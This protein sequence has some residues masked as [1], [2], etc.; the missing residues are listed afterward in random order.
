MDCHSAASRP[1]QNGCAIQI[2]AEHG[3]LH[4]HLIREDAELQ[5]IC[6]PDD[7]IPLARLSVRD[8]RRH[9]AFNKLVMIEKERSRPHVAT[10]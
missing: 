9:V 8:F 4:P 5:H 7:P 10:S 2:E 3:D 1:G 6:L